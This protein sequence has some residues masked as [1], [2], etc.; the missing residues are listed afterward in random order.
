MLSKLNEIYRERK[1]SAF[2]SIREFSST[3]Q[4][5]MY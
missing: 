2:K 1:E 5:L 3:P 4:L